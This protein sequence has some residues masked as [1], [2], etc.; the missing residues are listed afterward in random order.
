MA[1]RKILLNGKRVAAEYQAIGSGDSETSEA[2]LYWLRERF[3]QQGPR[4]GCG[5]SQCGACTVLLDDVPIRSCTRQLHTVDDNAEIRTL[6]GLS[7]K[8]PHPL[9]REFVELQAGQCAFC[10]NGMIMGSLGWIEGRIT[11]GN[12]EVPSEAEI[13][14]FLSGATPNGQGNY[15]CRCGTHTRIVAAIRSAAKEMVR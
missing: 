11:A 4:F 8:R 5:V 12:H 2:L 6:D 1:S 14:D 15:I 3:G 9:Q 7:G 13:E 10:A